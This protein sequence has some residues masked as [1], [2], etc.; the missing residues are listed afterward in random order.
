MING[1]V[2]DAFGTIV[3]IGERTSPYVALFREGRKQGVA[4]S[5][6]LTNLAMTTNLSFDELASRLGIVLSASKQKE[7]DRALALELS[8]IE[9]YPDAIEAVLRLQNVG[10]KL[11]ICSNLAAPYGPA[12]KRLFPE[13]DG[14]AFSYQLGAM[15]P[16]PAIYHA[17]CNQIGKEPGH[18]LGSEKGGL[19][20]IGDSKRCDQDGPRSIGIM[21]LYLDRKGRGSINDLVQF[22]E[23]VVDHDGKL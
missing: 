12:V 13:M 4:I 1:V 10:V 2:F 16:D 3:R 21:G 9:P 18:Y 19:V 8:S 22:A 17:I 14:Y 6:G 15:K 23:L 11:G 20:M 7:L 5:L